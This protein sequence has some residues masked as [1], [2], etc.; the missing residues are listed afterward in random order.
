MLAGPGV[1]CGLV[2]RLHLEAEGDVV[3]QRAVG[4]QAEML[5]HHRDP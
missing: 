2:H 1:R 5:E 4:Q 3:D